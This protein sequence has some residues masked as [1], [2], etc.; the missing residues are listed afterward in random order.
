MIIIEFL[1]R[2]ENPNSRLEGKFISRIFEGNS[3]ILNS[4]SVP[5]RPQTRQNTLGVDLLFKIREF[6]DPKIDSNRELGF[7]D[8]SKN[9]I[10]II[11]RKLSV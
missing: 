9:S 4:R 11:F 10:M 7:S 8:L 5:I 3:R 6:W 2:S 1:E